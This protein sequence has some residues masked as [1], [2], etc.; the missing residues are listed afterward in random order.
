M[1]EDS[2]TNGRPKSGSQ[3]VW[4]FWGASHDRRPDERAVVP[5]SGTK[6]PN[7]DFIFIALWKCEPLIGALRIPKCS[8]QLS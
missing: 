7:K 2:H 6:F 5:I 3:R 1:A 4:V 8:K